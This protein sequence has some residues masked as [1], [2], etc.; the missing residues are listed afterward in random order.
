MTDLASETALNLDRRRV[1]LQSVR[2]VLLQQNT[3][4]A[5]AASKARARV[6]LI[7]PVKNFLERLQKREHERAVG[8]YETLLSAFLN[9]VLPGERSV[10]MDLY[11]ERGA[12]ALDVFVRKSGGDLEDAL[13][14]TGGSVTNILSTGLRVIALLRSGRRRFLILDESDCW[15]K[16]DLIPKFAKTVA[17]I[18]C[19]LD[20]QIVMISHHSESLF[21]GHVDHRLRLEKSAGRLSAEWSPGSAIPVWDPEAVGIRSIEIKNFQSHE[22]TLVSLSPTVTLI[23]GDND[24]GKSVIANVMRAVFDQNAGDSVIRHGASGAEVNIDFGP[25]LLLNWKRNRSGRVRVAHTLLDPS[26]MSVRH[27]S[28]GT[29]TPEWLLNATGIGRSEGIDIQIGQQQTPVF[30]LDQPASTRAKALAVGQESGYIAGMMAVDKKDSQDAR[31]SLAGNEATLESMRHRLAVL[32]GLD[33]GGSCLPAAAKL[34]EAVSRKARLDLAVR[35]ISEAQKRVERLAL[36]ESGCPA[37]PSRGRTVM[38]DEFVRRWSRLDDLAGVLDG[39]G[40]RAELAG[41]PTYSSGR[42][43]LMATRLKELIGKT[44][45][46]GRLGRPTDGPPPPPAT[47]GMAAA[48]SVWRRASN[49]EDNLNEEVRLAVADLSSL[50]SIGCPTCHRPLASGISHSN[51]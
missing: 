28:E 14:G 12:P 36:P 34:D 45:V 46:L 37:A 3:A 4:A 48:A 33:E 43:G 5:H 47:P 26:D 9:D 17:Q 7:E 11:S 18:A 2:A 21:E 15:I 6:E 40:A 49:E 25:G 8:A 20:V 30:L 35:K 41:P 51:H 16:P 24:I 29:K 27:A 50:E 19:D 22:H 23:Q 31:A 13:H 10:V 42:A 32:N 1:A 44:A 39:L 38:M